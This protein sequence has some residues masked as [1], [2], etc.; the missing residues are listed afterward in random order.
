M[1]SLLVLLSLT[2]ALASAGQ[3][4]SSH[5][6]QT[7]SS[8]IAKLFPIARVIST[9]ALSR[10]DWKLA[11]AYGEPDEK[12]KPKSA[13]RAVADFE[14]YL[15]EKPGADWG[16]GLTAEHSLMV[17]YQK[18]LKQLIRMNMTGLLYTGKPVRLAKGDR[19]LTLLVSS[20][21]SGTTYNTL[22]F[23]SRERAAQEIQKT[24][25]PAIKRFDVITTSAFKSYGVIAVYGTKDFSEK[26]SIPEAELVALVAS[27][28]NCRKL[29]NAEITEEE[30]V[31]GSDIY[32][33]DSTDPTGDD[34]RKV[35]ISLSK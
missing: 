11:F 22:R 8:P 19:G 18:D 21:G 34:V 17:Q 16:V 15:S 5:T 30:F 35:K 13:E 14:E 1:K 2:A 9:E 23:E 7:A 26:D 32:I 10:T 28:E 4:T 31:S 27:P 25:L 29:A 20:L 6:V 12:N 3:T 33:V 24:I